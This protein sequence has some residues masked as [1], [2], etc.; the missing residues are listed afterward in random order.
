MTSAGETQLGWFSRKEK[1]RR[2]LWLL[3]QHTIFRWSFRRADNWRAFLLRLFGAKIGASPLIRTT[4]RVEVPWNLTV[5]DRSR[6]G[7]HLIIYNLGPI[8]I[9]SR[10]I[11][12][13]YSHLCGG[14]H[15]YTNSRMILHKVPIKIGSDVWICTDVYVGPGVVIGDGAIIGARSS[16]F[17]DLPPWKVCVG[18]PAKPVKD[19]VLE[20]AEE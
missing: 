12:S 20:R 11:I 15:D 9:G 2:L 10:T 16:V 17:N 1:A 14:T 5:G 13:Q 7:E 19:R 6:L 8:E 3:V 4:V 18:S